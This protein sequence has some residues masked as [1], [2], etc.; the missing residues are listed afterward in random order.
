MRYIRIIVL[1]ICFIVFLANGASADFTHEAIPNNSNAIAFDQRLLLQEANEGYV[2]PESIYSEAQLRAQRSNTIRD[3]WI[4]NNLSFT[5]K[6][7]PRE[8]SNFILPLLNRGLLNYSTGNYDKAYRYLLNAQGVM[9]SLMQTKM[10][11]AGER[12]KIFKG[13]H[14]EQAMASLYL[15]LMLYDKGDYENARAMFSRAIECDR[16]T[17]PVQEHLQKLAQTYTRKKTGATEQE[18]FAMFNALGN[19]NRLAY[20]MLARTYMKL[21]E[22]QDFE[23]SLKNTGN[24]QTVPTFIKLGSTGR[25]LPTVNFFDTAPPS[26]NPFVTKERL[27]RDNLVILIQM[28]FAPVKQIAGIEGQSDFLAPRDYPERKAVVYI[29][30]KKLGEAYPM[31]NLM[32]QAVCTVRTRKDTA[33]KGKAAGKLAVT[34]LSALVS[35]DLARLVDDKWSVAADT[36]RWGSLPNEVHLFSAQVEPGLHT[37]TVLFYGQAGNPLP[38]YE[39]T[40]YFVPTKENEETFLVLR[41]LRDKCNTVRDFFGSKLM[42]YNEKKNELVFNARDLVGITVGRNLDIVTVDFG[43]ARL[44]QQFIAEGFVPSHGHTMKTSPRA[45]FARHYQGPAVTNSKKRFDQKYKGFT[46]TKVGVARVLQI[47][48]KKTVC[49]LVEGKL[50]PKQT[51]FITDYQLPVSVIKEES[52]HYVV[53]VGAD[54]SRTSGPIVGVPYSGS[55]STPLR[56]TQVWG[57]KGKGSGDFRK[58]CGVAADGSGN[59]YVADTYNNRIQVFDSSGTFVKAWGQKGT[60]SGNLARPWDVAVDGEGSVY[61]ADTYNH[62]VQKFDANG[63]FL[64]QWG[65]KGKGEGAFAFLS[66]ITL[67]PDGAVYTVDAKMNRVQVFDKE[68]KFLRSWG[69]TGIG[70]GDFVTPMG[71]TVDENGNVYVADSK[72][73]R[74]QKFDSQGHFL[75][76]FTDSLTYP[77]DVAIDRSSGNLLILD[78]ASHLIWE[79]SPTG[80]SLRSYGGSGRSS[81][82]FDEPYGF[83]TDEASNI[84]VVDTGNSRVQ[85]FSH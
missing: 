64:G 71:L 51:Y 13:E 67:G 55:T 60:G 39:Q 57:S 59:I 65:Q 2:W 31:F 83:C 47:Q 74:V 23:I 14:Y 32:H 25:N 81:G 44:N 56:F 1:Y 36:R 41:S 33:Q 27:E 46:V 69:S 5:L 42:S 9:D 40:H 3:V 37:L 62:R 20:Y 18:F 66:G 19:D 54:K 43:D 45:M 35:D 48:G 29:D 53:S 52:N 63:V 22:S 24:W 58:P 11:M 15:G 26:D 82:E 72:M 8:D 49:T 34:I 6:G 30:G 21:D 38:H 7:F 85:K 84:F 76:A 68:G 79:M 4:A 28:G 78:A 73:R 70:P 16:E 50:D 17:V 12:A 77:V 61:V 80:Q 75:A 10:T